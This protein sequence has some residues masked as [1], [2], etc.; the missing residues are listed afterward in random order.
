MTEF[1]DLLRDGAA[2]LAKVVSDTA[3]I[4]WEITR[5]KITTGAYT[6]LVICVV[7]SFLCLVAALKLYAKAVFEDSDEFVGVFC[8]L[9]AAIFVISV[10]IFVICAGTSVKQLLAPDY[11]T[12]QQLLS[13]VR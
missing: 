9:G 13:L 12:L 11:Y 5:Q 3:P 4:V 1:T 10:G 6:N 8:F 2:M 7:G